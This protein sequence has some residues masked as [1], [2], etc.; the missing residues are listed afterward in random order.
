MLIVFLLCSLVFL[1]STAVLIEKI[2]YKNYPVTDE[3][4]IS[5]LI[6]IGFLVSIAGMIISCGSVY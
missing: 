5:A 4:W 1:L 6:L 2:K 3:Y